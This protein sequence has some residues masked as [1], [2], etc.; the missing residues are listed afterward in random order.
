M[1]WISHIRSCIRDSTKESYEQLMES[2]PELFSSYGLEDEE[3]LSNEMLEE[4]GG[5]VQST[6]FCG[7]N[8]S[9]I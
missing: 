3:Y 5:T 2:L 7:R 9:A 4:L 8:G 1:V 6:Y